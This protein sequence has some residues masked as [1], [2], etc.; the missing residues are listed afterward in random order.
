[1]SSATLTP[2]TSSTDEIAPTRGDLPQTIAGPLRDHLA[3]FDAAA[4]AYDA[5]LAGHSALERAGASDLDIEAADEAC[6]E[7][8]DTQT[9]ALARVLCTQARD[10][11][12]IDQQ[13]DALIAMH[14]PKGIYRTRVEPDDFQERDAVAALL[15]GIKTLTSHERSKAEALSSVSNAAWNQAYVEWARASAAAE[16]A[17]R[18]WEEAES[19][20]SADAPIPDLLHVT[21]YPNVLRFN[22]VD[23][24]NK[25]PGVPL[26]TKIEMV[27]LL[28]EW[29]PRFNAARA[30][31]QA[32]EL[33]D[34]DAHARS[35][36]LLAV[37]RLL[38]TPAPDMAALTVKFSLYMYY[39]GLD[40]PEI[41]DMQALLTSRE[42]EERFPALL[43]QDVLRLNGTPSEMSEVGAWDAAAW[44]AEFEATPGWAIDENGR[45]EFYDPNYSVCRGPSFPAEPL[46]AIRALKP[47]QRKAVKDFAERRPDQRAIAE[48]IRQVRMEV[49]RCIRHGQPID[50]AAILQE[51]TEPY[52]DDFIAKI[53]ADLD[54][55][56]WS[57]SEYR[58]ASMAAA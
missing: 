41:N 49:E 42:R 34:L 58:G 12:E 46:A 40:R 47:W 57:E 51:F 36:R 45:A 19:R 14:Y 33:N 21:E 20:V 56:G 27:R 32:Q 50:R 25:A 37:D 55:F 13:V 52:A 10:W 4:E 18:A 38:A 35:E 29:E 26:E 39:A 6:G 5:A 11:L 9:A 22:S 44:V 7:A 15:M 8:A 48:M 43:F 30:E 31:H 28:R 1:M 23:E 3:A 24:I 2:S 54:R 17:E 53:V 16:A